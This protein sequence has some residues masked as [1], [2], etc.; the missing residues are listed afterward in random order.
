MIA[1][2]YISYRETAC[3]LTHRCGMTQ[4]AARL[5][6][7]PRLPHRRTCRSGHC[8]PEIF[9]TMSEVRRVRSTLFGPTPDGEPGNDDLGAMSSWY[10]WAAMCLYSHTPGEPKLVVGTPLFT[11]ITVHAGNGRLIQI[12]APGAGDAN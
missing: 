7:Q 5:V 1:A 3:G 2:Q 4:S 10:V 8:R 6:P 9:P 11:R 12:N